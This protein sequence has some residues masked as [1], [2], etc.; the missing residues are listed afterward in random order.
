MRT[1]FEHKKVLIVD[2]DHVAA[3][4]IASLLRKMNF[5]VHIAINGL[6]AVKTLLTRKFDLILMDLNMPVMEGAKASRHIRRLGEKFQ[7]IPIIAIS[8]STDDDVIS[9]ILKEGAVN[10]FLHK[11]L[12]MARLLELLN[13]LL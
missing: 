1:T 9:N 2:D 6:E 13:Q 4:I 11:P 7:N 8:S 5:E 3:S 10:G 12:E